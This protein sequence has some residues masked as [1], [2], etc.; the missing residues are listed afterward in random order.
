MILSVPTELNDE[1]IEEYRE[2]YKKHFGEELP[3]DKAEVEALEFIR[4]VALIIDNHW[5]IYGLWYYLIDTRE[6]L[7][8]PR[9]G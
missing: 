1:Q 3:K 6:R 2:L 9:K 4:F 7:F 8:K 5:I